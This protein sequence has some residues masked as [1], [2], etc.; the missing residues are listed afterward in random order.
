MNETSE[1]IITIPLKHVQHLEN[2]RHPFSG[3]N[4]CAGGYS[5]ISSEQR[6]VI[7]L[8]FFFYNNNEISQPAVLFFFFLN[9]NI[10]QNAPVSFGLTRHTD[11]F[12]MFPAHLLLE[13]RY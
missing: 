6:L 10:E 2:S 12:S 4:L 13:D 7:L 3:R 11:S 9:D 8:Y 1:Y 5:V